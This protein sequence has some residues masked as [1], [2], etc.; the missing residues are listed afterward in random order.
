MVP[1]V[2]LS[3]DQLLLIGDADEL[4]REE[5]ANQRKETEGMMVLQHVL[6]LSNK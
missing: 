5:P 3:L 6:A 1:K 2:D 4:L